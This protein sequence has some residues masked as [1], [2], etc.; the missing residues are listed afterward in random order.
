MLIR[1]VF[2]LGPPPPGTSPVGAESKL[3]SKPHLKS[4]FGLHFEKWE[5][6]YNV[7][8]TGRPRGV[9][10]LHDGIAKEDHTLAALHGCS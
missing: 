1:D 10:A 9:G 7:C 2:W 6:C 5:R 4:R 8:F 3:R